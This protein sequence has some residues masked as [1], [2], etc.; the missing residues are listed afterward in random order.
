MLTAD[1]SRFVLIPLFVLNMGAM[2]IT[3]YLKKKIRPEFSGNLNKLF[4]VE[5]IIGLVCAI[6]LGYIAFFVN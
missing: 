5:N 1:F 2:V 3:L 4:F 6:A